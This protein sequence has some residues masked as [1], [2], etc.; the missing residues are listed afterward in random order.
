[1]SNAFVVVKGYDLFDSSYRGGD[2]KNLL[3]DFPDGLGGIADP[4]TKGEWENVPDDTNFSHLMLHDEFF[5]LDFIYT[6][7]LTA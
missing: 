7:L 1:M 4:M 3:S 2:L 5:A 6:L